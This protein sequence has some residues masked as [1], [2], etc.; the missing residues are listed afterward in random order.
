[1]IL[2]I[3]LIAVALAFGCAKQELPPG[4][5]PDRTPPR[6]TETWPAYGEAVSDLDGNAWIRFDEPLSDPRGVERSLVASPAGFY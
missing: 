2:R 5:A 3:V 6:V 4:T 1:M